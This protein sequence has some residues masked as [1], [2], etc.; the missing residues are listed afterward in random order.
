MVNCP[1]TSRP[2]TLSFLESQ[3]QSQ[4]QSQSFSHSPLKPHSRKDHF[5]HRIEFIVN[6]AL[7][8]LHILHKEPTGTQGVSALVHVCGNVHGTQ[9]VYSVT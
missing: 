2:T 7:R 3:S 4:S 5:I 9:T 6:G 1:M 8:S